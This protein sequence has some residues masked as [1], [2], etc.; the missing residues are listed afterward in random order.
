MALSPTN[1][2]TGDGEGLHMGP[3]LL[4]D[5]FLINPDS[6]L[7]EHDSPSAKA[8]AV[9]DRRDLG[10]TLFALICTPGL[11][12]RTDVMAVLKDDFITGLMP[13]VEWGT[14]FWPPLGQVCMAIIF[15][16]PLGGK[17]LTAIAE[18]EESLNQYDIQARLIEPASAAITELS[19]RGVQHRAIRT[20]NLYFMDQKRTEIVLGEC[21]SAPPGLDQPMVFETIEKAMSDPSGRGEGDISED[22]FALGVTVVHLLLGKDPIA[23]MSDA[24]HFTARVE[25]GTYAT[26]CGKA[27]IPMPLIE[28]LRG[29]L[30]DNSQ[31]RWGSEQLSLWIDGKRQTP[32]QKG[33]SPIAK[34]PFRFTGKAYLSPRMLAWA[35]S[36]NIPEAIKIIRNGELEKWVRRCLGDS[37]LGDTIAAAVISSKAL[38]K[39]PQGADDFLVARVG[40]IL[41]PKGPLRYKGV[42]LMPEG[43]G[44]FLAVEYLRQ[45]N[46][47]IAAEI[48]RKDVYALWFVVQSENDPIVS[49][50]DSIFT[51]LHGFLKIN[52]YGYGIERCLYELN[53]SLP[54]RSPLVAEAYVEN[55][56]ELL[57]ALDEAA[58]TVDTKLNPMDR[59]IAAFIISKFSDDVDPHLRAL[60]SEKKETSLI[61]MLSLLAFL[62]WKLRTPSLLGLSSWVGGLLGPAINTYHNINTRREIEREI[63]HLVRQGSLPEL[64]DLID[65]TEKRKQ[66]A[67]GFAVARA[68]FAV[69]EEE[70]QEIENS[71]LARATTAER[72][73]QQTAA[74]TS[75]IMAMIAISL[76]FLVDV[77]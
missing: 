5:H 63:P 22:I 75:I 12:P 34:E 2:I 50:L 21:V 76:M 11:P 51:Q 9:E 28:P 67:D 60:S 55:I 57:P 38:A 6:S 73:G 14:V 59:H 40:L 49:S 70:V 13:L 16:R 31:E 27:R 32:M 33:L 17:L 1:A 45:G 62:Q 68:E 29:M 48:I 53:P 18:G 20:A 72:M 47:Q 10:R 52:D 37:D 66:D 43:Y 56:E 74:T 26:L 58:N 25:H 36:K 7:E 64:F 71:D 46:V 30:S 42:S 35:F 69:A 77:I 39:V 65:N 24:Q 41:D 15:E 8:Y 44:T 23:G 61:G 19:N 54:C 4:R 3:A